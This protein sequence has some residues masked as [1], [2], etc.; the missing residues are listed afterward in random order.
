LW[1]DADV[2]IRKLSQGKRSLDDFCRRFHG[3]KS[4]PPEVVPYTLDDVVHTMNEVA[5]YDWRKFFATRVESVTP[6]PPLGGIEEGGWRIAYTDSIP[7]FLKANEQANK[8]VDL[9]FSLGLTVN[10]EDG[11]IE[12]AIPGMSAASA[13]VA[14]GMKLVAVN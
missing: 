6:H 7:A 5:P 12:D 3:G 2:I 10:K 11:M 8:Y 14:P 9:S 4:G 1:L 13:G